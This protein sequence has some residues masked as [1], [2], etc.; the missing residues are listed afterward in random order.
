MENRFEDLINQK[1]DKLKAEK[2]MTQQRANKRVKLVTEFNKPFLEFVEY[3]NNTYKEKFR[4]T[5][6]SGGW[7]EVFRFCHYNFRV[8]EGKYSAN[9]K[10]AKRYTGF[11]L[12]SHHLNEDVYLYCDNDFNVKAEVECSPYGEMKTFTNT[13]ELIIHFSELI[14]KKNLDKK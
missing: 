12:T 6:H 9:I 3:V 5:P 10:K 13:E 4:D 7:K 8:D 11:T 14:A 1:K 2:D